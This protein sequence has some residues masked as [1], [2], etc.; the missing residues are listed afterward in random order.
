[1]K[2]SEEAYRDKIDALTNEID[3]LREELKV[4]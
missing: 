4:A 1:M 3:D 2:D